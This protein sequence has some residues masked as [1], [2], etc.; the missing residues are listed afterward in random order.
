MTKISIF[1]ISLITISLFS[2]KENAASKI[3]DKVSDT[4]KEQVRTAEDQLPILTFVSNEFNFGTIDQGDVVTATFEYQNTGKGDLIIT[5][6]KASCGCTV[7]SW[8]KGEVIKPGQKGVIT[9]EF[10]S[11]SKTNKQNKSITL[12]TNTLK[13]TQKIFV[14]GFV[15]PDPKKAKKKANKRSIKSNSANK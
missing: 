7:P 13:R 1:I 4:V 6:A 15:T 5:K 10:N 8:P 3:P 14:K 11:K 12:T 2:C 9:A